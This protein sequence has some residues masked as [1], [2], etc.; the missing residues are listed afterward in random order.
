MQQ[1]EIGWGTFIVII[2]VAIAIVSVAALYKKDQLLEKK[3]TE[4]KKWR[5]FSINVDTKLD[6]SENN[7]E[8]S[9]YDHYFSLKKS[10]ADD[11]NILADLIKNS[12]L[13]NPYLPTAE[14]IKVGPVN[15]TN[16]GLD[17]KKR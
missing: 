1:E 3:T 8:Q 7:L 12:Q 5:D 2:L 14:C 11:Y 15:G 6:D 9:I 4:Q 13:I 16:F 10:Q 17:C